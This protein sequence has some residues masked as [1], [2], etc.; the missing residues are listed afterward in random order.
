MPRKKLIRANDLPYHLTARS[1]NREAFPG[2]L[3]YAWKIIT[4]ELYIQQI[5]HGVH[6]HSFV[7]MPNHFHLLATSPNRGID[8]VMKE[9]LG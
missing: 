2:E 8:L 7:L 4:S 6:F 3:A 5:L 9:V 1:N